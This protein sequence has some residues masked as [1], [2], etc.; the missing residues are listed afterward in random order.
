VSTTCFV[1]YE[2]HPATPGGCGVFVRN[3]ADDMLRQGHDVVLLLDCTPAAFAHARRE[4][5]DPARQTGRCT[6]HRV[7]DLVPADPVVDGLSRFERDSL[8]FAGALGAILPRQRVDLIEFF[9]FCGPAWAWLSQRAS[10]PFALIPVA[11]RLHG[12]LYIIDAAAGAN[13]PDRDRY[14]AYALERWS[15]AAADYV[16]APSAAYAAHA[17]VRDRIVVSPPPLV[18]LPSPAT[19]KATRDTI[20]FLGTISIAKGADLFI[21]ACIKALAH[22]PPHVRA[23]LIGPDTTDIGGMTAALQAR[24][25]ESFRSRI[26]FSGRCTRQQ[27]ADALSGAIAA[28]FPS[29]SESFGY[30]VHE[31]YEAGV[32]VVVTP[33]PAFEGYFEHDRN[34]LVVLRTVDEI[35]SAMTRLIN[36]PGLRERLSRPHTV[37]PDR[38][39]AFYTS[40]HAS[41]VRPP[42][43]Y[44]RKITLLVYGVYAGM[45]LPRLGVYQGCSLRYICLHEASKGVG[46]LG[47]AWDPS[48]EQGRFIPESELVTTDALAIVRYTDLI[49]PG[50][51]VE[52]VTAL[53]RDSTITHASSWGQRD[54]VP[55]SFAIDLAP[56][57]FP[58]EHPGEFPPVLVRTE[59]GVPLTTIIPAATGT[60]G[61]ILPIWRAAR[62][63]RGVTIRK[64]LVTRHSQA[65]PDP[66]PE[67]LAALL[68]TYPP[69]SAQPLAELSW[70]VKPGLRLNEIPLAERRRIAQGLG[71]R[72]L[73]RLAFKRIIKRLFGGEEIF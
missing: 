57:L 1:S 7:G 26:T 39:N 2:F 54:G 18:P 16:L 43:A 15:L 21:D 32:P 66:G 65:L 55:C 37:A 59:P 20:V 17:G 67:V 30:A 52:L 49:E 45:A 56:E 36:E 64:V 44:P 62:K 11:V 10:T 31:A 53:A 50:Y 71:A 6:L 41:L 48:D 38:L 27:I 58:F 12:P 29:H 60:L 4:M 14:L 35:T 13:A 51:L 63:G 61:A 23:V 46:L 19:R 69:P 34:A 9:D 24:I 73:I 40:R 3:A 8:R 47:K 5:N 25:P 42:H 28:V 68:M 33:L 70:L 22:A 72:T